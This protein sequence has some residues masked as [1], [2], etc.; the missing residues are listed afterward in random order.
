MPAL[1]TYPNKLAGEAPIGLPCLRTNRPH[2]EGVGLACP[3]KRGDYVSE[4]PVGATFQ[5]VPF[6][7]S[8]FELVNFANLD[9]TTINLFNVPVKLRSDMR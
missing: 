5:H 8:L 9:L 2:L 4:N 3:A 6:A 1:W 7:A